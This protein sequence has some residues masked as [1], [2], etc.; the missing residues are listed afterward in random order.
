MPKLQFRNATLAFD[1]V[2]PDDNRP[3]E[4]LLVCINGFQR[5]RLDFR[6][7]AKRLVR[8]H[9]S[10]ACVLIDNRG[11][12]ESI[13][14]FPSYF[15][16]DDLAADVH[17]VASH[18]ATELNLRHYRC[19]GI[20]MGGMIAQVVRSC[21]VADPKSPQPS[22][23]ILV[24]TT[25][26]GSERAFGRGEDKEKKMIFRPFP[27]DYDSLLNIMIKYF[28][29]RF[30]EKSL[31]AIQGMV[32]SMVRSLEES[33]RITAES[34]MSS[35]ERQYQVA[36][37]FDGK[38]YHHLNKACDVRVMTGEE[39][40]I[41]PKENSIR[42]AELLDAKSLKIYPKVGHLILM[43]APDEFCQDVTKCLLDLRD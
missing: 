4:T 22:Q 25:A 10:L 33:K 1:V 8:S 15:T 38:P 36:L 6:S 18:C 7:F 13:E 20:S 39:D 29:S 42:L 43:E 26:G 34:A 30:Q 12:G 11:V 19:L 31:P 5:T 32:K 14:D 28:G 23:L 2:L 17:A 16:I 40:L 3:P 35:A 37:T 24:S 27:S 9:P 21:A 41:I